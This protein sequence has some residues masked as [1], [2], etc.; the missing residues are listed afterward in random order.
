MN[1]AR[2]FCMNQ[3][4]WYICILPFLLTAC[5]RRELTYYETAEVTLTADWSQ[6]GLEGEDNYGATAVFYPKTGGEPK[7]VLMG[8]RNR[9]IA[10]LPE[11]HYSAVL[12][13]RS[14]DDFSA[15]GFRG[16]NSF[17]TIEAY[18]RQVENRSTPETIV[19]S[20]DKLA[21]AVIEEFEVTENMLG[22]NYTDRKSTRLNS[23]H[24]P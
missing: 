7:I 24:R 3:Y 10:L 19:S 8:N 4:I 17:N 14:F 22:N 2:K 11:G 16:I 13:N 5:D 9:A 23:S 6:S 21:V 18:A 12:F 15:I 20:P 1:K